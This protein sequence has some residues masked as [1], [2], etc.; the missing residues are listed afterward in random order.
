VRALIPRLCA[1][2]V[3][4]CGGATSQPERPSIANTAEGTPRRAVDARICTSLPSEVEPIAVAELERE[5][6]PRDTPTA[7]TLLLGPWTGHTFLLDGEL[8]QPGSQPQRSDYEAWC[9]DVDGRVSKGPIPR[10]TDDMPDDAPEC[11]PRSRSYAIRRDDEAGGLLVLEETMRGGCPDS[12]G[13]YEPYVHPYQVSRLD[14][15]FLVLIDGV[16]GRVGGYRRR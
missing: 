2:G 13:F 5:V 10:G 4:A 8:G 15:Q 14:E 3:T 1:I 7:R 12:A 9:F 11:K 16:T 6:T